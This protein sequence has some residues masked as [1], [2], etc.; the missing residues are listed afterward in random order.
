MASDQD[1]SRPDPGP[2]GE[3]APSA[4][5]PAGAGPGA[6][7]L[8][9]PVLVVL[10]AFALALLLLTKEAPVSWADASRLGTIQ[11]LVE[12]G[13]L[14]L[15]EDN[16]FFWQGDKL[17]LDGRFYSHQPPM[18]AL[19]G[20]LPYGL[21]RALGGA[22]TDPWVYRG[23]TLTLVGLPLLL[24]L[25]AMARL[26]RR[27]GAGPGWTAALV[28]AAAFGT[29]ALPYALVLNQHGAAAGL[30][31]LAI[32]AVDRDRPMDAGLLLALATTVDLTAV[33]LALGLA[34]PLVWRASASGTGALRLDRLVPYGLGA[35]PVLALHFGV[36]HAVSGG[37]LPLG[38][39]TEGFVYPLSPFLFM[40]LTGGGEAGPDGSGLAYATGALF[41]QSG[42]FSHHPVLLWALVVGAAALTVPRARP[43]ALGLLLGSAGIAA[44]Y[45]TQSRNFG[46]SSFGMRWFTVFAPALLVLPGLA[47]GAGRRPGPLTFAGLALWSALAAGLGAAQPWAKFHYRYEDSPRGLVARPEDPRPSRVA[48]WKDEWRR[49]TTL[50][51]DFTRKGFDD[52]YQKLMDQHQRLYL[53]DYPGVPEDE[54]RAWVLDGLSTLQH[55][56]DLLDRDNATAASRTVGHFWLG[57]FHQRLGDRSA[58]R[59][60]YETALALDPGYVWAEQALHKLG[61]DR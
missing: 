45:L 23:L 16:A 40:S 46:G 57:R 32:G 53:G 30:V 44:Y 43:L 20:A 27:H 1:E 6:P 8:G 55:A 54:L 58:A 33:F 38:L 18:L 15:T 22:I 28:A 50:E 11:A 12:T 37:L 17:L 41:G 56:V 42:L 29:L 14:E 19:A 3:G 24:G 60:S 26:L 7:A 35:L 25:G 4:P 10:A 21:F 31:L 47:V 34:V 61:H 52:L 2:R 59:R 39:R 36:T 49:V 5:R 9:R 13:S 51:G 48:H